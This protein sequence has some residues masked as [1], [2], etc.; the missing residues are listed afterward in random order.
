MTTYNRFRSILLAAVIAMIILPAQTKAGE[1]KWL[2]THDYEKVFVYTDFEDSDFIA[3]D[4]YKTIRVTLLRSKIKP[5][6]S[7]SLV[8]LSTSKDSKSTDPR[9]P[10][11]QD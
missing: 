6:I 8:F 9:R 3:E 10:S 7:N 5:T 1:Y 11:H 4:L 2:K